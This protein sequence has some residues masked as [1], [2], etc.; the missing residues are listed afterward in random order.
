MSLDASAQ[1]ESLIEEHHQLLAKNEHAKAKTLLQDALV[2]AYDD[3]PVSADVALILDAL[4]LGCKEV[5]EFQEAGVYLAQSLAIKK[6]ILGPK[7]PE[8]VVSMRRLGFCLDPERARVIRKQ[9]KALAQEL[10]LKEQVV[11]EDCFSFPP[12][13]AERMMNALKS[14]GLDG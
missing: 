7:H 14:L 5:E 11:T 9:T 8:I 13:K 3:K 2:D 10:G 6:L 12:E 4:A 1:T